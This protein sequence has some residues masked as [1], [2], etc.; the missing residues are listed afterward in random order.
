MAN[1]RHKRSYADIPYRRL[2]V[3]SPEGSKTE[4]RYFAFFSS[5]KCTVKVLP[6]RHK[7]DPLHVLRYAEEYVNQNILRPDDEIWLV[8]D[9]DTWPEEK[10]ATVHSACQEK[11]FGLALSNPC[12][13]YWLL[14]HFEDGNRAG[15][16]SNCRRKL[17]RH[18]PDYNK[19]HVE[20][21]KLQEGINQAIERARRQDVPPCTDW[22]RK[23]GTT[24]YRL[25]EKLMDCTNG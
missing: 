9:R 5:T 7:P 3:I 14:L 12:F 20:N 11:G 4:P 19:N 10:L 17:K 23:A 13:E 18:L 1:K 22:P 16:T 21:R 15:T 2:Y 24:V 8:I 25:V 6:N